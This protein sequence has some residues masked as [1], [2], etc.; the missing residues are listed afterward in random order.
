RLEFNN[1][2]FVEE[3]QKRRIGFTKPNFPS[4]NISK[5]FEFVPFGIALDPE[6]RV[7]FAGEQLLHLLGMDLLGSE[8]LHYFRIQRP[9]VTFSWEAITV[10]QSVTWEVISKKLPETA[11]ATATTAT[12]T[13]TQGGPAGAP[14]AVVGMPNG[15]TG[16]PGTVMPGSATVDTLTV[17][18]CNNLITV[19]DNPTRRG[20]SQAP[21]VS[22]ESSLH[23]IRGLLLKG[24]MYIVK[25]SNIALFLCM[26]LL[27]N[28]VEMREMGL[29]LNDLSMHNMSRE[30]VL[31]G[32]EHCSR[33]EIMYNRAEE[34]SSRL[35]DAHRKLE[36]TKA[37]RDDLLYSMLPRQVADFLRQGNDPYAT[38]QT[39]DEVS[40][41][42]AEVV[43]S[44]EC[45]SMG[46][47]DV[48]KTISEM[49]QLLDRTTDQYSV[50]KVET[51]GGV[52]MVVG[53]A[54][55]Y[56]PDHCAQVAA[57]A[58]H[59]LREVTSTTP[60]THN[61]RIGIHIGPVAAGVVGLKLPR[62]CL[63]GDTVNTA[64][65]MQT[66]SKVGRVHVSERCAQQLQK[67]G[68][69]TTFREK[70][71]IKGKGEMNTYWL[72]PRPG[73]ASLLSR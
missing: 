23:S 49:Y 48:M 70:L 66:N 2:G 22:Q 17:T 43:L 63:F 40:V 34:Y 68:F 38:C 30:M 35:E 61:L 42:F 18:N 19:R 44:R 53:G 31:K 37:W 72:E 65:R 8:F 11:T 36:E 20:S 7:R 55:E 3:M 71:Q 29:Y 9:H 54:P 27:N 28:L 59:M 62:Y 60:H 5:L 39:L 58:L 24:Q 73:D 32:W 67:F 64:S 50:F 1:R 4:F 10:F 47:M 13:A 12:A 26:P 16:M 25:E 56:R 57:L 52:Y 69:T 6:L 21:W 41:L 15:D 46:A 33:V 45:E 14:G 51:V